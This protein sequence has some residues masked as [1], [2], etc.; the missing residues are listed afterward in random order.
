MKSFEIM[1]LCLLTSLCNGKTNAFGQDFTQENAKTIKLLKDFPA[2]FTGRLMT[3]EVYRFYVNSK[4][5]CFITENALRDCQREVQTANGDIISTTNLM[6]IILGGLI[7][8]HI[9][10]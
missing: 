1:I 9:K 3:D 10:K 8:Y 4:D 2:P 7:V 6:A 5:A